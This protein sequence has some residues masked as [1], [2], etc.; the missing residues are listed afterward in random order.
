MSRADYEVRSFYPHTKGGALAV[1]T[2]H[3]GEF[4]RDIEIQ[5][6]QSRRERG[7]I[8]KIEWRDVRPGTEDMSWKSV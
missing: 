4:S 1:H 8:G 3:V 6:S 2:W 7:E 5:A